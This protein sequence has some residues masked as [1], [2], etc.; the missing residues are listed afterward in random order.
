[1]QRELGPA[2]Y[3]TEI[4]NWCKGIRGA[5]KESYVEGLTVRASRLS[6]TF[7]SAA[8]NP[9]PAVARGFNPDAT[10]PT[11]AQNREPGM[12][13]EVTLRLQAPAPDPASKRGS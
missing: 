2:D 13:Y 9:K 11:E 6:T 12:P 8:K 4:C 7:T 1:M 3:H 5:G 10:D